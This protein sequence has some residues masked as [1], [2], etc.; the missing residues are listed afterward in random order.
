[1]ELIETVTV[2]SGDQS[3]IEFTSIAADWTDLYLVLSAR[4]SRSGTGD[5]GYMGFNGSTSDFSNRSF[6]GYG[7][8]VESASVARL[9][10]VVNGNTSTASTFTSIGIYIPNYASSVTKSFSTE[11]I[12]ENNATLG[13]VMF[14]G[15]LWNNTA[16]ISSIE[17][18]LVFGSYLEHSTASLYGIL[19]GSDG[20]T[21]VA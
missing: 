6:L 17:L 11:A 3:S 9:F 20:T 1:M 16:A 15:N 19:A 7:S 8:T 13:Y 2:G 12:A 10:G 14:G 21:T 18:S 4:S 5:N